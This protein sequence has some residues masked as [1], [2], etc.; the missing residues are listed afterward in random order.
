MPSNQ[1]KDF[2]LIEMPELSGCFIASKYTKSSRSISDMVPVIKR[3]LEFFERYKIDY[4]RGIA[5]D[6]EG[7]VLRGHK[8]YN[9]LQRISSLVLMFVPDKFKN[10]VGGLSD[11]ASIVNFINAE[12]TKEAR[13]YLGM[14]KT[15]SEGISDTPARGATNR[16]KKP[17][18]NPIQRTKIKIAG[19]RGI[20]NGNSKL[21]PGALKVRK[22]LPKNK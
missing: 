17:T 22:I 16:P 20:H 5:L 11:L 4:C 19:G 8:E 13:L 15:P 6:Y 3:S 2:Q 1:N 14:F 7:T 21:K 12:I 9:T 10:T 18:R